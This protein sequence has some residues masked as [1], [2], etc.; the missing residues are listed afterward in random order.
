MNWS[1]LY[2]AHKVTVNVTG[3]SNELKASKKLVKQ[4]EGFLNKPIAQRD[5]MKKMRTLF[6]PVA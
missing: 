6:S 3:S 5:K 4:C 2:L 1:S